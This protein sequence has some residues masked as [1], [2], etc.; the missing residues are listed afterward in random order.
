MNDYDVYEGRKVREYS[1]SRYLEYVKN[2]TIA[3]DVWPGK[4]RHFGFCCEWEVIDIVSMTEPLIQVACESSN[5]RRSE[6]LT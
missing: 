3:T 2:D 5:I 1:K 6:G 4:I